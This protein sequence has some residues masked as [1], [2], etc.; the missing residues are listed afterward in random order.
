MFDTLPVAL[1]LPPPFPSRS[2]S[3]LPSRRPLLRCPL[4]RP[5]LP[6]VLSLS[7][8]PSRRPPSRR[9]LSPPSLPIACSLLR[10]LLVTLSPVA[11]SLPPP[12]PSR[13]L[14]PLPSR[15]PLS[16]RPLSPPSLPIVLSL[17]PRPS[18]RPLSRRP[19]SHR[20][21]SLLCSVPS[22]SLPSPSI[23]HV[24]LALSRRPRSLPSPPLSPVASQNSLPSLFPFPCSLP[25]FST[26]LGLS[27]PFP[28]PALSPLCSRRPR[29]LPS[30]SI[31]LALFPPYPSPLLSPLH[32]RR[33][34][35]T[36]SDPPPCPSHLPTIP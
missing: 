24:A 19:L 32:F 34:R 35:S 23:S 6:I 5:S 3:P 31:A 21:R 1:S 20:P 13:S 9:P 25:S 36:S 17:S 2:L 14:S 29:V 7:P 15:R 26:A 33:P 16:R 8:L 12:F 4:P 28:S 27:P 30:L 10:S 22:P 18:R 11:L